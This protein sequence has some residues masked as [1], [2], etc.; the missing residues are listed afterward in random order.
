MEFPMSQY[1]SKEDR[2]L[3]IYRDALQRCFEYL[4]CI[5]E[6]AAGGCDNAVRLARIARKALE[7]K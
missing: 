1:A 7:A 6:A 2:L 4:D 3:A 5:P